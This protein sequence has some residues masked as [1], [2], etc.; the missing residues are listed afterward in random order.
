MKT[1]LLKP[2]LTETQ[3]FDAAR[4]TT[5]RKSYGEIRAL[6]QQQK[7]RA[8]PRPSLAPISKRAR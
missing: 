5:K 8:A 7:N 6:A 3:K 2:T 1:K 4:G